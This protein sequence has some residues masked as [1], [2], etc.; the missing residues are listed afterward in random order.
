MRPCC[1]LGETADEQLAASVKKEALKT[2]AVQMGISIGLNAVPI[3]GTALA[4]LYS[5]VNVFTGRLMKKKMEEAQA[6]AKRDIE[7]HAARRSKDVV[8]RQEQVADEEAV[9]A[10]QLVRSGKPI[11]PPKTPPPPKPLEDWDPLDGWFSDLVSKG[12]TIVKKVG[13]EVSEAAK[14]I[15]G[16]KGV[17]DFEERLGKIVA[18]TKGKI[19]QDAEQQIAESESP[20][21]RETVRNDIARQLASMPQPQREVVVTANR[22]KMWL[23]GGAVVGTVALFTAIWFFTRRKA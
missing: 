3:V 8:K 19:D 7:S 20:A 4:A 15:T 10:E 12:K 6:N 13:R 21:F 23:V 1:G 9:K 18:D 16:Q 17:E 2:A 14:T 11:P 5:L 22:R